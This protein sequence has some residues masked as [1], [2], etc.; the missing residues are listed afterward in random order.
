[1]MYLAMDC[2]VGWKIS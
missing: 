1:M 2:F